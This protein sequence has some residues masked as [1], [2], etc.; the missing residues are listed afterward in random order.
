MTKFKDYRILTLLNLRSDYVHGTLYKAML[1]PVA[2]LLFS[3]SLPLAILITAGPAACPAK[4]TVETKSHSTGRSFSAP[5]GPIQTPTIT[6]GPFKIERKYRS[7]EGPYIDITL[8]V[9]D[10]IESK[11]VI[12]SQDYVQFTEKEAISPPLLD[13]KTKD[14]ER[15]LFWFKGMKVEVLDENNKIMPTSE[16][17]CHV[18]L[19]TDLVYR[20]SAFPEAERPITGRLVCLT[21]GLDEVLLPEGFAIPV[22]SDEPWRIVMQAA[23]RTSTQARTVKHRLTFYFIKDSDLI[24]PVKALSWSTPYIAVVTDRNTKQAQ[25]ESLS[26]HAH[27]ALPA[28]GLDAPNAVEGSVWDDEFGRRRSSH[29]VVPP[30]VQHYANPINI[31]NFNSKDRTIHAAWTHIH[32]LCTSFSLSACGE[33]KPIFSGKVSTDTR[34]G[35]QIKKIDFVSSSKGIPLKAGK[36]YQLEASYNNTTGQAHDSMVSCGIFFDDETFARPEWALKKNTAIHCDLR[37]D[38]LCAE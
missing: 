31:P 18:N 13:L 32:P 36:N 8:S 1:K 16:F 3:L 6:G 24:K 20:L 15:E 26:R 38:K 7:M 25:T 21:Q 10:I 17:V 12:A 28:A 34:A 11:N 27:C 33:S 29:W 35:L 23:N 14:K 4:S 2:S 5:E 9:A 19:D 22:G 30:G 37:P